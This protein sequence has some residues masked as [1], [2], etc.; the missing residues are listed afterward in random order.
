MGLKLLKVFESE[1]SLQDAK[2]ILAKNSIVYKA[3]FYVDRFVLLVG[4]KDLQKAN[5]LMI[6]N[7][8]VSNDNFERNPTYTTELQEWL[9]NQ[10]NPLHYVDG[11][12]PPTLTQLTKSKLIGPLLVI[13]G[14]FILYFGIKNL[15]SDHV[16]GKSTL[17]LLFSI[18]CIISG[19]SLS[20]SRKKH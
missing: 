16:N 11:K 2:D 18:A 7:G 6:E 12:T 4:E 13:M 10:Y 17:S 9:T 1:L 5:Q 20:L 3:E 14:V 8:W 15:Y 19:L